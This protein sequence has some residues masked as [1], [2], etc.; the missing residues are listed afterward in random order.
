MYDESNR[1]NKDDPKSRHFADRLEFV[2][3]WLSGDC[4]NASAFN[5]KGLD[6]IKLG[7]LVGVV[8]V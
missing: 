4:K 8:H 6:V 7:W 2:H 5:N 1:A 3:G